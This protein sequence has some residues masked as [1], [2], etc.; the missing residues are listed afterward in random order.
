MGCDSFIPKLDKVVDFDTVARTKTDLPSPSHGLDDVAVL[1]YS[2][3]TTGVPKGVQLTHTN[4]LTA[5]L[6]YKMY[7]NPF[8]QRI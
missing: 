1:P 2:S 7:R 5:V 8:I 6:G 3:G 4:F